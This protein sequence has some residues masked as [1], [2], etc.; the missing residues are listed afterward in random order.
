M[1]CEYKKPIPYSNRVQPV[2]SGF[3]VFG[4][5]LTKKVRIKMST[6]WRSAIEHD[7]IARMWVPQLVPEAGRLYISLLVYL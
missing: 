6:N 7:I 1:I 5:M 4:L 3:G 2:C